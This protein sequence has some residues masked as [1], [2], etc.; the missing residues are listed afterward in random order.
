MK[1]RR[2]IFI[3]ISSLIASTL[4]VG[5]IL[6]VMYFNKYT[7]KKITSTSLTNLEET[8]SEV[9]K[10]FEQNSRSQFNY[11]DELGNYLYVNG[12]NK[13]EAEEYISSLK[14]KYGFSY[15]YFISDDGSYFEV[16]GESG[17]LNLGSK[18]FNLD[19]QIIESAMPKKEELILYTKD[20][21]NASFNDFNY[22]TL[23]FGYD[24]VSIK[25]IIDTSSYDGTSLS[26]LVSSNGKV[27]ISFDTNQTFYNLF[28]FLTAY[29]DI[30]DD[31]YNKIKEDFSNNNNNNNFEVTVKGIT[32]YVVYTYTGVS[33]FMLITFTPKSVVDS[34]LTSVKNV[35]ITMIAIMFSFIVLIL[36]ISI[37]YLYIKN[38]KDKNN[39][40]KERDE[41]FYNA[42]KNLDEIYILYSLAKNK[43][44]YVSTNIERLL[45]ITYKDVKDDLNNLYKCVDSK[46]IDVKKFRGN[47]YK[48]DYLVNVKTGSRCLYSVESHISE[49]SKSVIIVLVSKERDMKI[50]EEIESS[51]E[52][53]RVASNAKTTFLSNMSHDIRTPMNA[54]I[55]FSNLIKKDVSNLD[56][57]DDYADKILNASSHLLAMLN[58]ILDLSKIESGKSVLNINEVSISSVID[59]LV[60]I[61]EPQ[62]IV[63]NQKFNVINNVSKD[64]V[65]Y[66]DQTRLSQILLNILS[67]AYK[68]TNVGGE[69]TFE[70]N[71][72]ISNPSFISYNFKISD[73]GIGMSEEYLKKLFVP[74][75]REHS[76]YES[77]I[78]GTGLGMSITKNLIDM[79]NGSINVTSKLGVGSTFDVNISFKLKEDIDIKENTSVEPISI[80]GLK[81]LACEDNELNQEI[82]KE[83]LIDEGVIVDMVSNGQEAVNKVIE[84][85]KYDFILM[86]I[87]MPV[88]DGY[89]ATKAIRLH[90][91][92]VPIIAMTANAFFEDE[93]KSI[94]CGMN[95]HISKPLDVNVLKTKLSE[96]VKK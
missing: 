2:I 86:D 25:N 72:S 20:V 61:I 35:S 28:E 45:G 84:G 6:F 53:A 27:R 12:S 49:D 78:E 32:R 7:N 14:E 85:N 57:V 88:M 36:G 81:V 42:T 11:L 58:D 50:R 69:I 44:K 65:V 39:M 40:I 71:E 96:V 52:L 1:K 13:E 51:L 15:F 79:M 68:Y 10:M 56:K 54:I 62:M 26:Y 29:S 5:V 94:E 46:N 90:D 33:D 73:N 75:E 89:E 8:Y 64:I 92:V 87:Q 63:K 43:V 21:K 66:A 17:R 67:N 4:V 24:K 83:M 80:K 82:L 22:S 34:S 38:A 31:D 70:I 3:L 30:T 77:K 93:I 16:S 19:E 48:E 59:S 37:L 47:Y 76:K 91:K 74:F 18:I 23:A 95:A 55:G 9:S 41:L 60:N